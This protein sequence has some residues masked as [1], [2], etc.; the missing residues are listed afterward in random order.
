MYTTVFESLC[1]RVPRGPPSGALL[2]G[3]FHKAHPLFTCTNNNTYALTLSLT[4]RRVPRGPPRGA[5]LL[6]VTILCS[7]NL[8]PGLSQT[9]CTHTYIP[10]P[11]TVQE[12]TTMTTPW[13]NASGRHLPATQW[14]PPRYLHS[15]YTHTYIPVQTT[16]Q[17]LTMRTTLWCTA[18]GWLSQAS[19]SLHLP[20]QQ[21]LWVATNNTT[22]TLTLSLT[23][24][25]VPRG[26]PRGALLLG[27]AREL[28]SRAAARTAQICHLL[29]KGAA[30]GLQV[31][32]WS[33]W[34]L[35]AS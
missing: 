16:E 22:H 33:C 12:G 35:D 17:E 8:H 19:P 26:P 21:L 31:S 4:Y 1:R 32:V 14:P 3:G 34:V 30:P 5:L 13:C 23:C 25:R 2:L 20:P 9:A 29:F 6:G 28:H 27:G 18:S 15:A 11:T 24:R 10:V 7:N